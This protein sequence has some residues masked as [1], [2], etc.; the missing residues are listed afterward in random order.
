MHHSCWLDW[1]ALVLLPAKN[2]GVTGQGSQAWN[3]CFVQISAKLTVNT[4][5]DIMG[6]MPENAIEKAESETLQNFVKSYTF[7]IIFKNFLISLILYV[8]IIS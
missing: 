6:V 5:G 7:D 2:P 1:G 4:S 3:I 8:I